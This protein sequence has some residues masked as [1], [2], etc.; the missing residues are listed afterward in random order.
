MSLTKSACGSWVGLIT[1]IHVCS[2]G[3]RIFEILSLL[4]WIFLIGLTNKLVS[5]E[6]FSWG[7]S[8]S[9]ALATTPTVEQQVGFK[10]KIHLPLT[11]TDFFLYI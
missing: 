10:L 2:H 9:V 4:F 7:N 11:S 5:L 1:T 3:F 8:F 6:F